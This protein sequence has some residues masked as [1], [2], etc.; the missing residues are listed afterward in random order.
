MPRYGNYKSTILHAELMAM[1]PDAVAV[2]LKKRSCQSEDEWRNDA[3]DGDIEAALLSRGNLAINLALAKYGRFITTLRPLFASG[4]TAEAIRLCVL[5]NTVVG[6]G[7][8]SKFPVDLFGGETQTAAWLTDAP[9]EELRALFENHN[10]DDSFLTDLL[11]GKKA[12]GQIPDIRLTAIVATLHRNERMQKPYDDPDSDGYAE[13]TYEAAFDAART[14]AERVEPTALWAAVLYNLYDRMV[15]EAFSIKKP[16]ELTARWHTDPSDS[17]AVARELKVVDRGSLSDYQGVRMCLARLALKK[18]SKLLPILLTSDD[19]ALRSAA[20]SYGAITPEQIS[21]AYLR[22]GEL[23]FNFASRNMKIWQ[24]HA[25]RAA[26]KEVA[27]EVVRAD[28]HSDMLAINIFNR[29]RGNFATKY[30][31]WFTDEDDFPPELDE[32]EKPATKA[33]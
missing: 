5:S 2:F 18:D 6:G 29:L 10:L 31:D 25:G 28:K 21:T 1:N 13:Y 19:P 9:L 32:A 11:R 7:L 20:Y 33:D 4:E 23:L 26:I 14:L 30:P 17:D 22:D 16:L 27:W 24:S 15:K 12:W 8:F 3:L